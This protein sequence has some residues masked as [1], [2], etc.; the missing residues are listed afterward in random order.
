MLLGDAYTFSARD[1]PDHPLSLPYYN[2]M[3]VDPLLHLKSGA[4]VMLRKNFGNGLVNGTIGKVVSFH[5]EED[6]LS[7]GNDHTRY[8]E[9]LLRQIDPDALPPSSSAAPNAYPVVC[10]NTPT[11]PEHV[12][13]RPE[14]F[15][16]ED[17]HGQIVAIR[18]QVYS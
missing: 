10:F 1:G 15:Q 11:G 7:F 18:T 8:T 14:T 4:Q 16:V 5:T 13:C 12:F 17:Q 2:D 3:P 6:L 9:G